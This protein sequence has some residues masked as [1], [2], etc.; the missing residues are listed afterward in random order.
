MLIPEYGFHMEYPRSHFRGVERPYANMAVQQNH[1][2]SF[3]EQQLGFSDFFNRESNWRLYL[4]NLI[5][6]PTSYLL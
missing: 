1:D 5:R 3:S 2:T 4:R 6:I